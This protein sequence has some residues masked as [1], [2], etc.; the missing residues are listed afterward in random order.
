MLVS[1]LPYHSK[2]GMTKIKKM[3]QKITG[4]TLILPHVCL[5]FKKKIRPAGSIV[6]PFNI[7][8]IQVCQYS[9]PDVA[10][11]AY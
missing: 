1:L 8:I 6:V 5:W 4:F 11:L 3:K 10:E 9:I 2:H 7:T